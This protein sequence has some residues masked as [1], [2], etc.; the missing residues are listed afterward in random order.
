MIVMM[1]MIF[2]YHH[3]KQIGW[4]CATMCHGRFDFHRVSERERVG[5]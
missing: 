5:G 2:T 1:G 4:L 3:H